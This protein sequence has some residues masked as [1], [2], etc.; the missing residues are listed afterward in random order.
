MAR[1]MK[2]LTINEVSAVRRAANPAA[3]VLLRKADDDNGQQVEKRRSRIAPAGEGPAHNSYYLELEI[4]RRG[5]AKYPSDE[6]HARLWRS[7]S[8]QQQMELLAEE[9]RTL[10]QREL[11]TER[12]MKKIDSAEMFADWW[13]ELSAEERA[14]Y[15][16]Q[17]ADIDAQIAERERLSRA[18]TTTREEVAP[19][20]PTPQPKK[21]RGEDALRQIVK[22]YGVMP[23]A[24]MINQENDAHGITEVEFLMFAGEHASA[25]GMT[26]GKLLNT[27]SGEGAMLAKAAAICRYAGYSKQAQQNLGDARIRARAAQLG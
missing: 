12:Q 24:K 4:M 16:R 3:Q 13:S 7:M 22:S 27:N 23:L 20:H 11:D 1:I 18:G 15:R 17:Q 6:P 2:A 25:K 10:Q 19:D 14:R 5:I 26:L 9:G 8:R 21:A